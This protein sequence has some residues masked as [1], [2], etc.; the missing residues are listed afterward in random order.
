MEY[1]AKQGDTF[2]SI[3]FKALGNEFLA[4]DLIKANTKYVGTVIFKG[5]E[6]LNIPAVEKKEPKTGLPPW[7]VFDE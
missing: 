2:D 5:G 6:V 4:T 3:A 1:I 7:R